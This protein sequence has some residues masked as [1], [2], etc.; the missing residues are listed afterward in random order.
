M[1]A[2]FAAQRF[3]LD[4]CGLGATIGNGATQRLEIHAGPARV[5]VDH[6]RILEVLAEHKMGVEE[7]LV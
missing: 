4:D 3:G 2:M 5:P 1:N 7:G 6:A